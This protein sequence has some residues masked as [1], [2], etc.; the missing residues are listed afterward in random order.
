MSDYLLFKP[1]DCIIGSGGP[2]RTTIEKG[3][4]TMPATPKEIASLPRLHPDTPLTAIKIPQV[5][6]DSN[7]P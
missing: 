4:Q 3:L 6:K 1:V 7:I 5:S 2:G